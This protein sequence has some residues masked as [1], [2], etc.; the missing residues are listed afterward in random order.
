MCQAAESCTVRCCCV[1]LVQKQAASAAAVAAAGGPVTPG[2]SPNQVAAA[3]VQ[4]ILKRRKLGPG[5]ALVS[6]LHLCWHNICV[7]LPY[8]VDRL[9][10]HSCCCASHIHP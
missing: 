5:P 6:A 2:L 7:L 4:D 9:W 10:Q 3:K 1:L 8:P